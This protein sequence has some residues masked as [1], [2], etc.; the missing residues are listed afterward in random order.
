MLVFQPIG[1]N[2]EIPGILHL[3]NHGVNTWRKYG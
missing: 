1:P 2:K 3:Q